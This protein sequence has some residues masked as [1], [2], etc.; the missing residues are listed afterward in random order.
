MARNPTAWQIACYF[1]IQSTQVF[2]VFGWFTLYFRDE[3]LSGGEASALIAFFPLLLIPISLVVPLIIARVEQQSLLLFLAS[4][5]ASFITG[6][7][8]VIGGGLVLGRPQ[9]STPH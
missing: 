2:I 4:D 8:H 3:G 6:S 5:H 1:G 9:R 7:E